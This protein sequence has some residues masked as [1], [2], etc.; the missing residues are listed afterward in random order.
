[1]RGKGFKYQFRGKIIFFPISE[2]F[3]QAYL[4]ITLITVIFGYSH[5]S[6][7]KYINV[8]SGENIA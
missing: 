3:K 4:T 7:M 1:M 8:S 6:P 2:I 5:H